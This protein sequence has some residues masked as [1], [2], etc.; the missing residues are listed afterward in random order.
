[1]QVPTK[2][3]GETVLNTT[4]LLPRINSNMLIFEIVDDDVKP[5]FV[6]LVCGS[7]DFTNYKVISQKLTEL[8]RQFKVTKVITGDCKGADTLASRFCWQTNIPYQS[9]KADW[10][11]YGKA[12]GP[13]RNRQM[14]DTK[15]NLVVAFTDTWETSKGTKDTVLEAHR[16]GI[17]AI[18]CNSQL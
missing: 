16:R 5:E 8:V 17:R 18:V 7:R 13:I 9:F 11:Q 3:N 6:L 10:A 1:M 12:A 4:P 15:P 14:L 2:M